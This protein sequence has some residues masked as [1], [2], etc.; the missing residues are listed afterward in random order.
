MK[1]ASINYP[2]EDAD[3]EK[4]ELLTRQYLEILAPKVL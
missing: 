4:L 1:I 3:V 2:K